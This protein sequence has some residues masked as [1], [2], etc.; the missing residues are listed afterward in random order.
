MPAA[1]PNAGHDTQRIQDWLGHRSI[2]HTTLYGAVQGLLKMVSGGRTKSGV[3]IAAI[4]AITGL[5]GEGVT[6]ESS[7][8]LRGENLKAA[9]FRAFVTIIR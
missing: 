2:Q 5:H 6:R 8:R 7:R 1:T 3:S 9:R 4:G